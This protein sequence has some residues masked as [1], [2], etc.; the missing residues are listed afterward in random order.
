MLLMIFAN[1]WFTQHFL[2]VLIVCTFSTMLSSLTI[3]AE[4]A[5]DP[6]PYLV[7]VLS[8]SSD[9]TVIESVGSHAIVVNVR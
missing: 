9:P 4:F 8:T 6:G 1:E 7:A 3:P 5:A 2:L